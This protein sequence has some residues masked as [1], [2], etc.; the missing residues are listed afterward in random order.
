MGVQI[1]LGVQ[2]NEEVVMDNKV[3]ISL[4]IFL[5][6]YIVYVVVV[7][8]V[9]RPLITDTDD[10]FPSWKEDAKT[11]MDKVNQPSYTDSMYRKS[12]REVHSVVKDTTLTR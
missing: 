7:L 8:F 2:T 10:R 3:R 5:A 9:G 12:M 11:W 1:P 6:I 4:S